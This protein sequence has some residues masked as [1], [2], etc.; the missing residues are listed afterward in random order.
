VLDYQSRIFKEY[1]DRRGTMPEV[2]VSKWEKTLAIRFPGKIAKAAKL[3]DGERVVIEALNGDIVI[4]RAVPH[5]TLKEL[6]KGKSAKEWRA[7]YADA[8]DWDPTLA[9]RSSRLTR[10]S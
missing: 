10:R 4:R 5:F 8:F 7:T 1:P 6:F 3:S 9:L 2:T